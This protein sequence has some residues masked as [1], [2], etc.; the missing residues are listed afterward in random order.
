[1]RLSR[2]SQKISRMRKK[3]GL[4]LSLISLSLR[5][6]KYLVLIKLVFPTGSGLLYIKRWQ[7]NAENY[8]QIFINHRLQ[9]GHGTGM[10]KPISW[11]YLQI[12]TGHYHLFTGTKWHYINVNAC[13]SFTKKLFHIAENLKKS[14]LYKQYWFGQINT[15]D[16]SVKRETDGQTTRNP[17]NFVYG[18]ITTCFPR[19]DW[20]YS[21]HKFSWESKPI[22][23]VK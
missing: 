13:I 1:M 16:N 7:K 19:S 5:C 23:V 9:R 6:I 21:V 17:V 20:S 4:Q 22:C 15:H 8:Q 10:F 12:P 3:V 18:G 11:V 14:K 2:T